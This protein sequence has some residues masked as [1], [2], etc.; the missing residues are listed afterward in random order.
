MSHV[1]LLDKKRQSNE[2]NPFI[3]SPNPLS[4]CPI[5]AW[6]AALRSLAHLHNTVPQD[7]NI[8]RGYSLPPAQLFVSPSSPATRARFFTSWLKLRPIVI[9]AL[10]TVPLKLV[11]KKWHDMMDV[12]S[13]NFAEH[14]RTKAARN[15]KEMLDALKATFER[16][17]LTLMQDTFSSTPILWRSEI[18]PDDIIPPIHIAQ[19]IC[20]ELYELNFRQELMTLDFELDSSTMVSHE[21][22]ELLFA[23]WL[24]PIDHVDFD[25]THL[26]LG[27]A[28]MAD[29][30][31]F[32]SALHRV[33]ST[34][35]GEK[36]VELI[37]PFPMTSRAHN[38]I[39][40]LERVERAIALFYTTSFFYVFGR[41]ASIPHEPPL[42]CTATTPAR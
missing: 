22:Q 25:N 24:G 34:W 8:N 13:G 11:N 10:S 4:P 7:P 21:R 9:H 17:S 38:H 14:T 15:H 16:T 23:C 6:D 12:A 40:V 29:R 30:L 26:G 19:Q 42:Q 2:R 20:W 27:G 35:R 3:E 28:A 41:A 18:L 39:V 37:D 32:L 31:P 5:P 1:T 33:M 36:P